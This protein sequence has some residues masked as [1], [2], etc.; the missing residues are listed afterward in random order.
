MRFPIISNLMDKMK[1]H[2]DANWA[3]SM[4]APVFYSEMYRQRGYDREIDEGMSSG[5]RRLTTVDVT[6]MPEK[7]VKRLIDKIGKE[8]SDFNICK[9]IQ[10]AGFNSGGHRYLSVSGESHMFYQGSSSSYFTDRVRP[11]LNGT[12]AKLVGYVGMPQQYTTDRYEPVNLGAY[13]TTGA[14][15]MGI[16]PHKNAGELRA[17]GKIQ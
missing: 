12:D 2:G 5:M 13:G 8:A 3:G 10:V 17:Q 11:H 15:M 6:G 1:G 16:A 14:P 7:D 9:Q 4:D